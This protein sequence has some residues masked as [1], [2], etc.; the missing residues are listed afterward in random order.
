MSGWKRR[1]QK[2]NKVLRKPLYVKWM[3]VR[4]LWLAGKYRWLLLHRPFAELSPK[5]GE[6]GYETAVEAVD[7][8][9]VREVQW[10]VSAVCRRTPWE[11]KC[12]VQALTAKKLLNG[13]GLQCTLYMG[14][15]KSEEGEMLAHAWLRCGN[16]IVTGA[17]GRQRFTVTTIYGDR[18]E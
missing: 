13:Y 16:R 5:I 8:P 15:C 2:L 17:S 12:L 9:E 14:V 10:A 18:N 3:L 1:L 7:V 11:S 4:V 6:L